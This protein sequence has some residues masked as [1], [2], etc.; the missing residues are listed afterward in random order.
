[1]EEHEIHPIRVVAQ[2]TGL[3]PHVIRIWERR[4]RAVVPSRNPTNRRRFSEADIERLRCLR[5]AIAAGWSIGEVARLPTERITQLLAEEVPRSGRP[6]AAQHPSDSFLAGCLAAVRELDTE[7]LEEVL[8]RAQLDLG[9]R[10]VLDRVISPLF[11]RIGC[12]WREDALRPVHEHLA[13][14]VVRGFLAGLERSFPAPRGAPQLVVSTPTRQQHEIGALLVAATA[15]TEGWRV[16]YLGPNLPAPEIASAANARGARA[17]ALSIVF[18]PDDAD[19]PGELRSLRDLL[20]GS[21]KLLVGGRGSEAYREALESIG[22]VV[23]RD[24][25]ELRSYLDPLRA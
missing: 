1:V 10:Q 6:Q 20:H 22:A 14:A 2:R 9:V 24:L 23:L 17:V 11:D 7:S 5:Q 4:Y 16:T 18:P 19:L 3:S 13:S 8:H 21:V 15:C 25:A 12:L